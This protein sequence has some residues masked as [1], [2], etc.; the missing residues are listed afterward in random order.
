MLQRGA[1]CGTFFFRGK[2]SACLQRV[3]LG[4]EPRP[5]PGAVKRFSPCAKVTEPCRTEKFKRQFFHFSRVFRVV[6]GCAPQPYHRPCYHVYCSA[7]VTEPWHVTYFDKTFFCFLARQY[8]P[9]HCASLDPF[10]NSEGRLHKTHRNN[11]CCDE[12]SCKTFF[13]FFQCSVKDVFP[14]LRPSLASCCCDGMGRCDG[15]S[16]FL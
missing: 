11:A 8:K 5:Y 7:E 10:V 6:L 1:K 12:K 4:C 13:H 15:I 3:V 2:K 9:W 14:T 16:Y